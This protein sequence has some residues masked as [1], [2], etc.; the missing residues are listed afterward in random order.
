M[1]RKAEANRQKRWDKVVSG[2]DDPRLQSAAAMREYY[3]A[4]EFVQDVVESAATLAPPPEP[5]TY[6]FTIMPSK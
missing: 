6:T 5:K 4:R 3:G 1:S 2:R